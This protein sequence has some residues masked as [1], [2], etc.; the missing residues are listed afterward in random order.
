M[1]KTFASAALLIC[2][3]GF[4]DLSAAQSPVSGPMR[5]IVPYAAGGGQDFIAR[6]IG[7]QLS[8]DLNRPVIIENKPG[9]NGSV[10]ASDLMRSPADGSTIMS[11]DNGHLIFSPDLYKNLTYSPDRDMALV[12]TT[13][14]APL[15]LIAGPG[16]QSRSLKVWLAETKAAPGKFSYASP[17]LGSPHHIAMELIKQVSGTFL[18]HIPYRGGNP[19]LADVAAGQVPVMVADMAF[20]GGFVKAGK[21]RAL[22]VADAVR[23]PQLPDVPTFAELGVPAVEAAAFSAV[24]V[25]A[26]TP[27]ATVEALS[28]A[29]AKA[30]GNPAVSAKLSGAGVEPSTSTPAEFAAMVQRERVRWKSIHTAQNIK[31]D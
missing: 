12:S 15:V 11:V 8:A 17:G 1:K 21:V 2:L 14:R 24:V 20:A 18:V 30:V 4:A 25:A 31:V 13:S 7:Q 23:M 27:T 6:T 22:A 26:G 19:A 3:L 10:A 28:R 5:W 9:A 29:L 16:T